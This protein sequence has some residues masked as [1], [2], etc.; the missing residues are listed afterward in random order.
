MQPEDT[1]LHEKM[2]AGITKL[3]ETGIKDIRSE[4]KLNIAR[5]FILFRIKYFKRYPTDAYKRTIARNI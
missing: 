1:C 2:V 3:H 5:F 4:D